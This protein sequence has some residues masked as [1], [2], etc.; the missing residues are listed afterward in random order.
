MPAGGAPSESVFSATTDMVTKKRNCLG[1]TLEQMTIV[2]HF[3]RS[4]RYKFDVL[5]KKMAADAKEQKKAKV[6]AQA[7][8][9]TLQEEMEEVQFDEYE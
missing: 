5:A 4:P 6:G 2:R 7:R 1:D 8:A 3:V 9:A